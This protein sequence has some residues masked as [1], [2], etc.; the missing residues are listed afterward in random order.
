M[1]VEDLTQGLGLDT[2][3]NN[4]APAAANSD[5]PDA[6]SALFFQPFRFRLDQNSGWNLLLKWNHCKISSLDPV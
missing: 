2:A 1:G 3:A 4:A 6:E 5:I